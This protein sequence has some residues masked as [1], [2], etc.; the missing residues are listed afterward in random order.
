MKIPDIQALYSDASWSNRLFIKCR[1]FLSD[2]EFV[3]RFVPGEGVIVDLGCGHGLFTNLMALRSPGRQLVGVDI[4]PRKIEQARA[5]VK[6]RNNIDYICAEISGTA[7]PECDVVTIVDV[8]YL[9][10]RDD[11]LRILEECRRKLRKGGVLLW[12]AQERRP[13]WK[14]AITYLQEYMTTSAGLTHG[15]RGRLTFLSREEALETL[16]AAGFMAQVVEMK[17]LRPYTD[18]LYVCKA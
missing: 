10:P 12:K 2:L 7:V 5:S 6:G 13:R 15:R 14:F 9:L 17:S 1:I 16:R 8:L 18:I 3:E 11:Q 4:S